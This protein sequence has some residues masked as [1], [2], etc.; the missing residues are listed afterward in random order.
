VAPVTTTPLARARTYSEPGPYPVGYTSTRLADGRQVV[1]WY[2]TTKQ[3]T[4]GHTREQ[5]DIAG[6]LSPELQAKIPADDRVLY[7]ADAYLDAKP[8]PATGGYPVVVFSHGFAGFPEQSV[9]LTTHLA[10]W[11]YVVAAPD[12]VERSLDGLLGTAARGVTKSTNPKC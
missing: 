8:R 1:V 3:A 11:G 9:T 12:H 10:S 4:R 5:I 2:P 6:L 7:P